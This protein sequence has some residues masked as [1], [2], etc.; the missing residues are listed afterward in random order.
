M[1]NYPSFN[2]NSE[3]N[4]FDVKSEDNGLKSDYSGIFSFQN[5]SI[6]NDRENFRFNNTKFDDNFFHDINMNS[7]E[8]P[9]ENKIQCLISQQN[10]INKEIINIKNEKHNFLNKKRL[11]I[12]EKKLIFKKNRNNCLESLFIIS[13]KEENN[14]DS[15]QNC[16][17]SNE[18][19]STNNKQKMQIEIKNNNPKRCDSILIK[20]KSFVGKSFI[21]YINEKIK[22]ITKRRIK[23]YSFNYSKFT[24]NVNYEEN[25]KWLAEKVKNLLILGNEKNQIKNEKSLVILFNK[26]GEEFIKIKNLMEITYRELIEKFYE[27][28]YFDQFKKDNKVIEM[29]GYFKSVMN[30]SILE[31]NGFIDFIISRRGN[32]KSS[33]K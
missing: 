28:E 23:F 19:T 25:K 24:L 1:Q 15:V 14:I 26:K 22:K 6:E 21:Q 17:P 4:L 8:F 30:L 16:I 18:S 12:N 11:L 29:D 5:T 13:N 2:T 10:P 31:K 33:K 27:S 20:F 9:P 3:I 7:E 32:K